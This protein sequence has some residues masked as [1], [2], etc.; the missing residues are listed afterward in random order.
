TIVR[1]KYMSQ[2]VNEDINSLV[3]WAL[4]S[5]PVERED[6]DIEMSLFVPLNLD[7]RDPEIQVIF[8]KDNF[9]LWGGKII[10]G[11]YGGMTVSTSIHVTILNKVTE[12]NKCPL[13]V[14]LVGISQDAPSEIQDDTVIKM[15]VTDYCGQEH[16]F[17]MK[18]SLI[19]VVGQMEIISNEFYVYAKEINY[20]DIPLLL[21]VTHQNITGSSKDK[22]EDR[23]L[24]GSSD[25]AVNSSLT[26]YS[27]S[28]KHACVDDSNNFFEDS[29]NV[30]YESCM[31]EN[32]DS[33]DCNQ[34][35][36]ED[37][38]K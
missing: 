23:V 1:I 29:V 37:S 18:E 38:V 21:L 19:F 10:S 33:I 13:K 9:F 12:S 6:Y 34:E 31:K 26:G 25:H 20:I 5:Y 35:V 28:T 8:E 2:N 32:D 4:D 17:V 11:Y 3:I 7:D 30:D 14:S 16:N 24:S 22:L 27:D 36:V 15:L